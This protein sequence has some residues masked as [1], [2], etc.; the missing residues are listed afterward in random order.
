MCYE[1][2][3]T[4]HHPSGLS[5]DFRP[6]ATSEWIVEVQERGLTY[7][8][9][10][11]GTCNAKWTDE[12]ITKCAREI[13]DDHF[14]GTCQNFESN[15]Q[16]FAVL[17]LQCLV[18]EMHQQRIPHRWESYNPNA[19]I[20]A[21]MMGGGPGFTVAVVKAAASGVATGAA[22]GASILDIAVTGGVLT[23]VA[24]VTGFSS[25]HYDK[26]KRHGKAKA[27]VKAWHSRMNTEPRTSWRRL[28]IKTSLRR[29][30]DAL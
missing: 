29:L 2:A 6:V 11:L 22:A 16:E 18:N 28:W 1:V 7:T 8:S 15:C 26:H 13:W 25:H 5:H 23:T 9:T 20:P 12:M 14:R 30:W 24:G 27:L 3:A 4:P 21:T 19:L 10:Y 17:L